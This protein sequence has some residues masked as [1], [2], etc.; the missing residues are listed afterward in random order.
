MITKSK[1]SAIL[2]IVATILMILQVG[3]SYLVSESVLVIPRIVISIA[4]PI[5]SVLFLV[6]AYYAFHRKTVSGQY[7]TTYRGYF[8][9]AKYEGMQ[10]GCC[11]GCFGIVPVLAFLI[12]GGSL[13]FSGDIE[14]FLVFLPGFAGGIIA[15]IAGALAWV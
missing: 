14:V 1:L 15:M 9:E 6:G 5:L 8:E 12:L 7:M 3:L 13:L 4:G 10:I 11:C 2:F